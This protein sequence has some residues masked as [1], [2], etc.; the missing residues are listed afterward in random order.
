MAQWKKESHLC[1]NPG[2][3]GELVYEHLRSL[4][5]EHWSLGRDHLVSFDEETSTKILTTHFDILVQFHYL[6]YPGKR[7]FLVLEVGN[8]HVSDLW[9]QKVLEEAGNFD[10]KITVRDFRPE[11][12]VSLLSF[13]GGIASGHPATQ[14]RFLKQCC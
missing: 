5:K 6:L 12:V 2:S 10:P 13:R 7:Q 1:V 14:R 4:G 8:G 9:R 11:V 3:H